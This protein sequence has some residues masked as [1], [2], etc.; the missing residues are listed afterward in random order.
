MDALAA[1]VPLFSVFP[2]GFPLTLY[3][4]LR[5]GNFDF[6]VILGQTGQVGVNHELAL[7]LVHID[8]RA[9]WPDQ[10]GALE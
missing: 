9:P 6:D 4:E 3:L 10:P 1:I 2:T 8:S 5:V 7:T